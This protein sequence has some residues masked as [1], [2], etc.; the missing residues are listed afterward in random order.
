[1]LCNQKPSPFDLFKAPK[2]HE[3]RNEVENWE[4]EP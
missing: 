1:M 3:M 4:A 2:A